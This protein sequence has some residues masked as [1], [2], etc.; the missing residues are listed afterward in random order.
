MTAELRVLELGLAIPNYANPPYGG[1]F[2]SVKAFHRIGDHV[3]LSG[4]T[5]EDRVGNRLHPGRVGADLSVEQGYEAAR[6]AAVNA[7]GLMRLALGSLDNVAGIGRNLCFVRATD[8][9]TEHHL[10]SNGA[11]DLFIEVFGREIGIAG[12]A[13]VGVASLSN[14]ACFELWTELEAR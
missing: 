14:D 10:V 5:P 2:G 7:L 4:A 1:R 11:T 6:M 12:R 3:M 8:D 13:S 9:F